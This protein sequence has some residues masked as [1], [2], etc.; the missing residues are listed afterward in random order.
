MAT[1]KHEF[2]WSISCYTNKAVAVDLDDR[3]AAWKLWIVE[4]VAIKKSE[5]W[6]L[7]DW[8]VAY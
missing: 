5:V 3:F 7:L 1:F 6:V 2:S 4:S 8:L